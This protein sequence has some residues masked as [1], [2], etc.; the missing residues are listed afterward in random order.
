LEQIRTT[1]SFF[2]KIKNKSNSTVSNT[3]KAIIHYDKFCLFEYKKNR[4]EVF[5]E[6]LRLDEKQKD[7]LVYDLL[8][9]FVNYLGDNVRPN[10]AKMYFSFFKKY[11]AYMI[12]SK[13]HSEDIKDNIEF[14][15]IIDEE[16]YP[17]T[18]EQI[19]ELLK[20]ASFERQAF[21]LTLATSGMRGQEACKIRKR[22][23][24]F[25]YQRLMIKLPGTYTKN[26]KPRRVIIGIE[27]EEYVKKLLS[28]LKDD[29]LVFGTNNNSLKA[30]GNEQDAFKRI[31]DL[32]GFDERYESGTHKITIH[33]LR[34]F[35]ITKGEKVHEGFAHALA[36]HKRY[37]QKYERFS[38]EE[39]LEAYLK[40]E[41][42]LSIFGSELLESHTELKAKVEEMEKKIDVLEYGSKARDSEF[43]QALYAFEHGD[44]TRL[45]EMLIRIG[46]ELGAP[47]EQKRKLWKKMKNLKEDETLNISD[48][49]ES[50]G[51][52]FKN[53]ESD[54]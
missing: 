13:I 43:L 53:L 19:R 4:D 6:I 36:G 17:L 8:Q 16:P 7:R 20:H 31:R 48:F 2:G 27:A 32:C 1:E 22:D 24:V 28:K 30:M 26:K 9:K 18:A 3:E 51:L 33:S 49:G 46:L 47:E 23:F 40:I 35:F 44:K 42:S 21:Y 15:S 41:P 14:P 52:S 38:T 5:T 29:D 37:M 54:E 34:S 25:G 50:N 12:D 10:T 39:L 11:F 45:T